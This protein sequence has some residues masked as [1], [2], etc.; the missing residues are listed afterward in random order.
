ML[1][2]E[3]PAFD[4]YRTCR[5]ASFDHLVGAGGA[6]SGPIRKQTTFQNRARTYRA[7]HPRLSQINV[8][9]AAASNVSSVRRGGCLQIVR[10]R[11]DA[12]K[13][14]IRSWKAQHF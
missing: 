8:A 12:R 3:I 13:R 9:L 6:P 4:R 7:R 1:G 10:H 14:E 5:T 2:K 11:V